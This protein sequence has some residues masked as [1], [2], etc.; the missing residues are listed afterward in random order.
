MRILSIFAYL[1][2]GLNK[3]GA[4]GKF[5]TAEKTSIYS[6]PQQT[7]VYLKI[8]RTCSVMEELQG[9]WL[10]PA[11][12]RWSLQWS[13]LRC[14]GTTA[15]LL[16]INKEGLK[17]ISQN[18]RLRRPPCCG[19]HLVLARGLTGATAPLPLVD[20][21]ISWSAH[22]GCALKFCT[23]VYYRIRSYIQNLGYS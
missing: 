23:L 2:L 14:L 12:P 5:A 3:I 19:L 8:K 22:T 1:Y 15:A 7:E 4:L 16:P 13:S 17:S 18:P 6:G 10:A 11:K 9:A 21:A 20:Y